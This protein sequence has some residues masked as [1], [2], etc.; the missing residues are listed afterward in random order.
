[1]LRHVCFTEP[2][3]RPSSAKLQWWWVYGMGLSNFKKSKC[4]AFCQIALSMT[5]DCAIHE[6]LQRNVGTKLIHKAES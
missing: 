6:V 4:E 3:S 1:M 5:E 2:N